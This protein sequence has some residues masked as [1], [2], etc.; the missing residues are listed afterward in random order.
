[1]T[2]CWSDPSSTNIG[3]LIESFRKEVKLVASENVES[4]DLDKS[5]FF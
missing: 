5:I 4:E 2:D 3:L 1:M